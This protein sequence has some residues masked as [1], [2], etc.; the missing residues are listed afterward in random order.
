MNR[1][2]TSAQSKFIPQGEPIVKNI[3]VITGAASG[4]GA[5]AACALTRAGHIV[6]GTA[7][8]G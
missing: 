7:Q 4:F 3:I 5:L 6:Y 8:P 2:F 1:T